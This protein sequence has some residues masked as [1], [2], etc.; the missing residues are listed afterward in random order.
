MAEG[1]PAVALPALGLE[2]ELLSASLDLFC[3][4]AASIC[5]A[6]GMPRLVASGCE[7]GERLSA[8]DEPDWELSCGAEL[9]AAGEA[10]CA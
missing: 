6:V 2:L 7:A 9:P 8:L 3:A 4:P 10:D 1:L 5:A